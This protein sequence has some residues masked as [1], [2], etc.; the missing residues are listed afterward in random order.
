MHF[1]LQINQPLNKAAVPRPRRFVGTI[2]PSILCGA[3]DPAV[4]RSSETTRF[5]C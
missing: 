5:C 2:L 1:L 4:I 3:R